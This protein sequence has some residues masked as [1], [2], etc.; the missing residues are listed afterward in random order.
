MFWGTAEQ[1]STAGVMIEDQLHLGDGPV[2]ILFG[3]GMKE[4]GMLF[5]QE[6]DGILGLGNSEVSLI[7]QVGVL[8]VAAQ[9]F[10]CLCE[11]ACNIFA[12]VHASTVR[13]S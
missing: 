9:G 12:S 13:S 10:A 3:C 6:A 8:V 2:E 4:T 1:S 7:N 5:S 11:C